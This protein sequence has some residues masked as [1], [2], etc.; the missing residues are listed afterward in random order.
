[1]K[2]TDAFKGAAV[3]HATIA[4]GLAKW[5]ALI[6]SKYHCALVAPGGDDFIM[7]FYCSY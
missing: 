5:V 2:C 6:A 3:F 7:S 4:A 1:M